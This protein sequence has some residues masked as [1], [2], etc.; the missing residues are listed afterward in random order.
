MRSLRCTFSLDD[1]RQWNSSFILSDGAK[2]YDLKDYYL[3]FTDPHPIA[4]KYLDTTIAVNVNIFS[5]AEKVWFQATRV[6]KS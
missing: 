4:M 1:L 3:M 6:T 5:G 2:K